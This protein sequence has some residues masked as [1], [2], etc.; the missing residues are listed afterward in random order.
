MA[1]VEKGDV[2]NAVLVFLMRHTEGLDILSQMRHCARSIAGAAL[3]A[4][5]TI[6]RPF[7]FR[8]TAVI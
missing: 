6:T 3:P 1:A 8:D 7:A 2:F 5:I 4:A